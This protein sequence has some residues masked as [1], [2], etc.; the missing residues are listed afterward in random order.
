MG[1]ARPGTQG[2]GG[3]E[4]V[5]ELALEAMRLAAESQ[6]SQWIPPRA[7]EQFG[8]WA[9]VCLECRDLGLVEYVCADL[10]CGYDSQGPCPKQCAKGKWAACTVSHDTSYI[11]VGHVWQRKPRSE[12]LTPAEVEELRRRL[13]VGSVTMVPGVPNEPP[14][15]DVISDEV[16]F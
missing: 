9:Y 14:S 6:R 11:S 4:P 7:G 3:K 15:E 16:P 12:Q 10:R 1:R 13:G 2:G 5:G 8:K